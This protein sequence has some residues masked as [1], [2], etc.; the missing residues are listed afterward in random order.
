MIMALEI[1]I[2]CANWPKKPSKALYQDLKERSK[3]P[4]IRGFYRLNKTDHQFPK[5]KNYRIKRKDKCYLGEVLDVKKG[6]Y[7][8]Y[9]S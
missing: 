3:R 2:L 6:E 7:F 4:L 5:L 1:L 9:S 8:G